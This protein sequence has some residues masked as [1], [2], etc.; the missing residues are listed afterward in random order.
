MDWLTF[1]AEIIKSLAWPLL[2]GGLALSF[3]KPLSSFINRIIKIDKDGVITAPVPGAQLE[4]K[5][6]PEIEV[7][8]LLNL[9]SASDLITSIESNI[10]EELRSKGC[11]TEGSSIKILIR[12]LAGTQLLLSF[13]KIQ[14]SI[15]GSQVFLLKKLN[16]V[17]GQ[18]KPLIF[19]EYY[20]EEIKSQYPEAFDKWSCEQYLKFLYESSLITKQNDQIHITVKG[21]E[22]LTWLIRNGIQENR[23]L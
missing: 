20:F 1:F 3:H 15:F 6:P 16:E 12:H 23:A 13:E 14:N 8:K 21:V 4:K 18:G 17:A 2:G 7:E 22:Y 11:D 10:K 19:T 5:E 9:I